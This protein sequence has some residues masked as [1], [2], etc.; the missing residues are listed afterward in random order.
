[1]MRFEIAR[2]HHARVIA[3]SM[4]ARDIAEIRAGW[5]KEPLEAIYEAMHGSIYARTL[6]CDLEPLCMYGLA[7]LSVLSGSARVWVF[8]TQAIDKHPVAF[9]RASRLGVAALFCHC[10]LMTNL[11]DSEDT[12]A[13][14]WLEWL[15]GTCVLPL[16]RRGNRLFAQFVLANLKERRKCQRG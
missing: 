11:V 5:D 16:H 12:A 15:G 1:M 3:A 14:R 8:G 13:M 9:A 6:F 2:P 4:R 7:P 10:S